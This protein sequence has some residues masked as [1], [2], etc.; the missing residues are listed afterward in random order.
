VSGGESLD[1]R[2]T[3]NGRG[4]EFQRYTGGTEQGIRDSYDELPDPSDAKRRW[5]IAAH[6]ARRELQSVCFP[7]SIQNA[8]T[9]DFSPRP[10]EMWAEVRPKLPDNTLASPYVFWDL[11]YQTSR[12]V[13]VI[14]LV[15]P[16]WPPAAASADIRVWF[17]FA[18]TQP[19]MVLPLSELVP[20]VDRVVDVANRPQSRLRMF[21]SPSA[22]KD[23]TQVTVI[24]E[25]DANG[26][27]E[28]PLLR[29]TVSP[30]C[31]RAVHS[32]QQNSIRVRHTFMVATAHGKLPAGAACTVTDSR[33]IREGAVGL[34]SDIGLPAT[35]AVPVPTE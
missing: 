35:L 24:E 25:H 15:A 12:P 4:L 18:P 33:R 1:L 19:D 21:L 20:G 32:R 10:L 11:N 28:A 23:R 31:V 16:N 27:A 2:V 5:F 14:D 6:L 34:R 29:V 9:T 30:G 17:R 26:A 22:E 8:K 3:G 7:I 13:P